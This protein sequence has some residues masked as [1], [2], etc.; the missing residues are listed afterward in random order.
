MKR[1]SSWSEE[2]SK[3]QKFLPDCCFPLFEQLISRDIVNYVF[4]F[5]RPYWEIFKFVCKQWYQYFNLKIQ[6]SGLF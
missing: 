4:D 1:P 6:P 2:V 5:I 3:K